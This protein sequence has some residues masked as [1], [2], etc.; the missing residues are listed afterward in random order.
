MLFAAATLAAF[1]YGMCT[2]GPARASK[3]KGDTGC[4]PSGELQM[5]IPSKYCGGW[6]VEG[7]LKSAGLCL[8][9]SSLVFCLAT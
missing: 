6:K 9:I 7:E 3:K 8:L 5:V 4:F 1:V 2:L